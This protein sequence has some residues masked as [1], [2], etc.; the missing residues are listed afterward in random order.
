MAAIKYDG[1]KLIPAPVL[2]INKSF[3]TIGDGTIIGNTYQINLNGTFLPQKGSPTS[4]GTFYTS[5]G[6]PAD[7]SILTDD[8]RF[9]SILKKQEALRNLF[10]SGNI[11]KKLEIVNEATGNIVYF[12][13]RDVQIDIPEGTWVLECPYSINLIA[14]TIYPTTD[15]VPSNIQS[16][17][18]SWNIEPDQQNLNNTFNFKVSH[19]IT[20]KGKKFYNASG[21][22]TE[23]WI[24]AKI[25]VDARR[26]VDTN[27]LSSGLYNLSGMTAYNH[28]V[29][30]N[31]DESDG[32][33]SLTENWLYA[34]GL[35][36]EEFSMDTTTGLEGITSVNINGTITGYEQRTLQ[37]ITSSRWDNA[38]GYYM[39]IKNSLLN[40]A[41]T[42]T[43]ISLNPIPVS[44]N[45]GRNPVGGTISYGLEYNT[46]PQTYI[47]GA[48]SES[49]VVTYNDQ[50]KAHA[51]VPVIG[52]TKGPVLQALGTSEATT[53]SLSIEFV[54]GPSI[55]SGNIPATFN[56][57]YSLISGLV[58]I[59]D[60][61][62][63]GALKSFAG[64][65][66]K[67]WEPITGRGSFN[68]EW[69][70]E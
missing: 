66:Q 30:T 32:V 54:L 28:L 51:R 39:S 68:I 14:D 12:Y 69:T 10:S 25:W 45:I 15:N 7:E 65:P 1:K 61:I 24:A 21:L 60:P 17:S 52:R 48:K 11:G 70:Y 2:S 16:A 53:K 35:A 23:P 22:P 64:Q 37:N 8:T 46:R 41:Q 9:D 18:E 43:G 62:N 4:S 58:T 56:F 50:S 67:T 40:R 44:E 26:G 55:I 5:T 59:L 20:A 47:S 29:S 27:L 38:S 33:Y 57:P 49:I 34:S 31:I 36:Y 6:Y 19:T 42:Y 63:L 3:D 13:P